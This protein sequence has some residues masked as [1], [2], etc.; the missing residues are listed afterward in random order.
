MIRNIN[1]EPLER[2]S[3]KIISELFLEVVY[4]K[5]HDYFHSHNNEISKTGTK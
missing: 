1:L 2:D 5:M 4:A 3:I